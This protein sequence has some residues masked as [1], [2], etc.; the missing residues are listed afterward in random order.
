MKNDSLRQI[1][2]AL[3]EAQS[4]DLLPLIMMDGDAIGSAVAL[5]LALRK[6]GKR[7]DYCSLRVALGL[8]CCVSLGN[9][10]HLSVF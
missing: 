3:L 7:A 6:A 4:I 2:D 9:L 1:A 10:S 8:L 5:C